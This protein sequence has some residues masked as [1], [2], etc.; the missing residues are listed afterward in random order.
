MPEF[1]KAIDGFLAASTK[2]EETNSKAKFAAESGIEVV[3]QAH[4]G[5]DPKGDQKKI[6]DGRKI[7]LKVL[8]DFQTEWR[9]NLE[10]LKKIDHIVNSLRP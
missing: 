2:F 6:D 3:K 5:L 8:T 10:Y 4:F 1:Y 9:N 7:F